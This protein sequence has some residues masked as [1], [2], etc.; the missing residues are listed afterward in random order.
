MSTSTRTATS[1]DPSTEAGGRS[2]WRLAPHAERFALIGV[3]VVVLVVFS[4][5]RPQTYPTAGNLQGVL[6]SQAVLLVASL[7]VLL[8]LITGEFDLS[9]ASALGLSSMV[10]A[11]MN[12]QHGWSIGAAVLAGV[13]SALCVGI[14]NA[15]GVVVFGIP[16]FIVTLGSGTFALG[17]VQWISGQSTVTGID[18]HLVQATVGTRLLG[19]P[20]QFFYGLAAAV[21]LAALLE[22]TPWDDGCSSSVVPR[23][24]RSCPGSTSR[25]CGRGRSSGARPSPVSPVSST[26]GPSA[27]PTRPRRSRSCCRPSP[28]PTSARPRSSRASST[29]RHRRRRVLPLLRGRRSA[30]A[31]RAELRP[32]ALLRRGAGRGRRPLPLRPPPRDP[33]SPHRTTKGP[34][35]DS[36][37]GPFLVRVELSGRARPCSTRRPSRRSSARR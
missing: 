11:V 17:V 21:L 12:V 20:L 6:G 27:A 28:R 3:W 34:A 23:R 9:V 25:A 19:V 15:L 18:P 33:L 36:G 26:P 14:V 29:P 4:L 30:D 2:R 7:G 31:G 8:P 13:A 24:W 10:T 37:A 35:P 5:A 16:S 32:A 22:F 1:T